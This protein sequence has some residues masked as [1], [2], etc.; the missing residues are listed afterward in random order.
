MI[1]KIEKAVEYRI[2]GEYEK[3]EEILLKLIENYIS[4]C[5]KEY[6]DAYVELA[7]LYDCQGREDISVKMYEQAIQFNNARAYNNL[8]GNY[9]MGAGVEKDIF[10]AKSL[11]EKAAELGAS[12]AYYSLYIIYKE[13]GEIFKEDINPEIYLEKAAEFGSPRGQYELA[14]KYEGQRKYVEAL[15][16]YRL[17]IKNGYINYEKWLLL[18]DKSCIE[19]MKLNNS[20][21][22]NYIFSNLLNSFFKRNIFEYL[23]NSPFKTYDYLNNVYRMTY[24]LF[25]IVDERYKELEYYFDKGSDGT[26]FIIVEFPGP[27]DTECECNYVALCKNIDGNLFVYTSEYYSKSNSFKMC[28]IDSK[29]TRFWYPYI[30][31]GLTEFKGMIH[32]MCDKNKNKKIEDLRKYLINHLSADNREIKL[33]LKDLSIYFGN[34]N[35]ISVVLREKELIKDLLKY[36]IIVHSFSRVEGEEYICFAYDVNRLRKKTNFC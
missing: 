4:I 20:F 5:K 14:K 33:T 25:G 10:K 13:Y 7:Y 18:D 17:A 23:Y 12:N 36:C 19:T 32:K 3:S 34:I 6:I 26:R 24:G 29:G 27:Y 22:Y 15:K 30:T 9:L 2:K 1:D 8:G 28:K 16:L 21:N 31:N 35:C 11:V